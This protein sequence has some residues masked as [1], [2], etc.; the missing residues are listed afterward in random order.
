VTVPLAEMSEDHDR[1]IIVTNLVGAHF[2]TPTASN[3]SV[4]ESIPDDIN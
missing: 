1:L 3:G 2:R 4:F